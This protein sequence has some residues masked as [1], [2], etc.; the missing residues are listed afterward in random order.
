MYPH[1]IIIFETV[2]GLQL[3]TEN[4]HLYFRIPDTQI[5]FIWCQ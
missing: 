1:K 4:E 5:N 2:K 3:E